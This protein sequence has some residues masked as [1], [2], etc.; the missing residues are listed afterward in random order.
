MP[1]GRWMNKQQQKQVRRQEQIERANTKAE[2]IKTTLW[3]LLNIRIF[4]F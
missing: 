1:A 4:D 3:D 2:A